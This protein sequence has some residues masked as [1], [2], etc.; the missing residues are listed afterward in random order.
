MAKEERTKGY[1]RV[2]ISTGKREAEREKEENGF[3]EGRKGC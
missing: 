2:V 1:A 3:I